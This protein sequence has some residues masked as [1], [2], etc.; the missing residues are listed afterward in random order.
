MFFLASLASHPLSGTKCQKP[1]TCPGDEAPGLE[2]VRGIGSQRSK[3]AFFFLGVL[4]SG[5]T[6]GQVSRSCPA[7]TELSYVFL[8]LFFGG[9]FLLGLV[10]EEATQEKGG[11]SHILR[12]H[13]IECRFSPGGFKRRSSIAE[14]VDC[15]AFPDGTRRLTPLSSASWPPASS[16]GI[17]WA[18]YSMVQLE[19]GRLVFQSWAIDTGETEKVSGIGAWFEPRSRNQMS[20]VFL[21]VSPQSHRKMGA[22]RNPNAVMSLATA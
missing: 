3:F 1:A 7:L 9:C 19:H 13:R 14:L 21:V 18:L 16:G 5:E 6:T 17:A 12:Q 10:K 4:P 2:E 22:P 11:P 8:F 20:K 15:K